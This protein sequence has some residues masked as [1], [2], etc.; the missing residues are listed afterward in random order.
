MES[1]VTLLSLCLAFALYLQSCEYVAIRKEFLVGGTWAG[2]DVSQNALF[3][4]HLYLRF[5]FL[6]LIFLPNFFPSLLPWAWL[7]LLI[8]QVVISVRVKSPFSGGVEGLIF[9]AQVCLLLSQIEGVGV[10]PI[11]FLAI[12]VLCSYFL[13]GFKKLFESGWRNGTTLEG[14]MK[15]SW[16]RV[17]RFIQNI[18]LC[19]FKWTSWA[20]ILTQ[21]LLPFLLFLPSGFILFSV[22]GIVFH[23]SIFYFFGL[24]RFFWGWLACYPAVYLLLRLGDI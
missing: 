15:K 16:Y 23:L 22:V 9:W 4:S 24:N 3:V 10:T 2:G 11:Y 19:Q 21:M 18:S 12:L 8:S 6:V 5:V 17:P 1:V 14:Y 7:G 20:I 13:A